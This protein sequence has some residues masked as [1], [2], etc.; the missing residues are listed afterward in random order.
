MRSPSP[1]PAA[2]AWWAL[3]LALGLPALLLPLVDLNTSPDAWAALPKALVLRPDQGWPQA[4]WSPWTAAW[5]HGSA[6]HRWRNLLALGALSLA[7]HAVRLPPRAVLA[8]TLAWPCTQLGM[9]WQADLSAYVGLSGVLHAIW[10]VIALHLITA[11]QPRLATLSHP[12]AAG[13]AMLAA[14][15]TK[16]LMENPWQMNAVASPESAINVTP[17]VHFWGALM[18]TLGWACTR[19]WTGAR[20]KGPHSTD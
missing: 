7:G 17:W 4:P 1:R 14:L 3:C 9:L 6:P 16:V 19:R 8:L 20:A 2:L 5:L 10:V 18:G 12:R 13:W 15:I 11:P